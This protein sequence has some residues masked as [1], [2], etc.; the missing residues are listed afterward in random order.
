MR[1]NEVAALL[2]GLVNDCFRSIK[3]TQCAATFP[4]GIACY[5]ACIVIAFLVN[6]RG[7]VVE[8]LEEDFYLQNLIFF[9]QRNN[10]KQRNNVVFYWLFQGNI[11]VNIVR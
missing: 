2:Y 1:H 5:Q 11:Y 10:E 6:R 3:G 4:L 7:E 8:E 9:T